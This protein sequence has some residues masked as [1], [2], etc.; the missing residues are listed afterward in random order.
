MIGTGWMWPLFLGW[1][2]DRGSSK[3]HPATRDAES[4]HGGVPHHGHRA[5]EHCDI[6]SMA[7]LS[8]AIWRAGRQDAYLTW[9]RLEMPE[10]AAVLRHL[11]ARSYQRW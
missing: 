4:S 10:R 2:R 11:S 9:L 3:P 5:S 7:L 6:V 8:C 1:G